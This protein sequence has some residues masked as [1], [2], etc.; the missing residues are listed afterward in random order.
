MIYQINYLTAVGLGILFY[1]IAYFLVHE[2]LIHNR[3][4]KLRKTL[5]DNINNDYLNTLI[6]AHKM[7]HKHIGKEDGESFGML[8]VNKKYYLEYEYRKKRKSN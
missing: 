2:V 1:G 3:F 5:F 7:H 4:K 8:I 6:Y